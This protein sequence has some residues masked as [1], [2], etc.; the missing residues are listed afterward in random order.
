M[1]RGV[2]AVLLMQICNAEY[3]NYRDSSSIRPSR[4]YRIR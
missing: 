1:N 4:I 2:I 3:F